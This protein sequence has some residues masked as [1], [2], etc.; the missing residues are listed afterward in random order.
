MTRVRE[1]HD[2]RAGR[3]DWFGF[4]TF[5]L[6]LGA[7]V[8]GLIRAGQDELGRR[9]VVVCLV[10]AGG[11]A[12][13]VRG[14]PAACR[15]DPM[16]D[17]TL[18]RKP[19]FTGGLIAAFGVSASVFSL[20]TYLVIYVQNVL[21][22]SAVETGVRFLFLSGAV[23]LRRR[24]RRPAHREGAGEVADRPGLPGARRRPAARCTASSPT[25]RGPT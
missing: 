25:R 2:P 3:P 11:A 5:S 16:F 21:G 7:L 18:L 1:S 12:G 6:A 24:D 8:Y 23:L 14:Q 4:V 22:Y 17:L 20:L 19:T 15:S 13:G 9:P 10:A